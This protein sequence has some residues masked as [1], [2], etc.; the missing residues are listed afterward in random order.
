PRAA[1]GGDGGDGGGP[2]GDFGFE[3]Y[4]EGEGVPFVG[5][6]EWRDGE[7]CLDRDSGWRFDCEVDFFGVLCGVVAE[8]VGELAFFGGEPDGVAVVVGE[9]CGDDFDCG[10]G[11][12]VLGASG[13]SA[14][15]AAV[16]DCDY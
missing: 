4:G 5:G 1:G 9:P 7:G 16:V 6:C 10:G 13:G 2:A 11:V 14:I 8:E 15:V 3:D 12:D